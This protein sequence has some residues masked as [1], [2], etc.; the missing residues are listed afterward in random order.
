MK[1]IF[2]LSI[3]ALAAVA[4]GAQDKWSLDSC[5]NYAVSH[6]ISVKNAQVQKDLAELS[7]TEAKDAFL[8]NVS[9]NASQSFNFGRGLTN[10][11]TY[12]NRNTSSF[13][14]GASMS[15]PLFDGLSNVRQLKYAKINLQ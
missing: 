3:I 14:W 2:S 6:S 10:E 13:S 8:P 9:A 11:N 5:I 7:V 12:E 1:R 4:A 15:L